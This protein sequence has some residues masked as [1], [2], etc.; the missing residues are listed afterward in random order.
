MRSP[1]V[2]KHL[3]FVQREIG[4]KKLLDSQPQVK[5]E[6]PP[7][8][9]GAKIIGKMKIDPSSRAIKRQHPG[10]L[11]HVTTRVKQEDEKKP[12]LGEMGERVIGTV[13][14]VTED[15]V[16]KEEPMASSQYETRSSQR[17]NQQPA[18]PAG[19]KKQ[20]SIASQ[21]STPS[22]SHNEHD[23][24]EFM[25]YLSGVQQAIYINSEGIPQYTVAQPMSNPSGITQY[26]NVPPVDTYQSI[27]T[28]IASTG[29]GGLFRTQSS[30]PSGSSRNI[31]SGTGH[32]TGRG[33]QEQFTSRVIGHIKMDPSADVGNTSQTYN[34][35]RASDTPTLPQRG[36][37][38]S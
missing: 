13:R 34:V 1:E 2:M 19:L 17:T 8:G 5:V 27:Q 12:F 29:V 14:A 15:V 33:V 24:S 35:T 16:K 4:V 26:T 18:T 3:Q 22:K 11:G 32:V 7:K 6:P 23:H 38:T 9:R 10:T 21:T 31:P 25:P 28:P 30:H 20:T 36:Q 37:N